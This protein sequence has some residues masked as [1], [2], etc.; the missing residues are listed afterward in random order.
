ME[1]IFPTIFCKDVALKCS[2]LQ[3]KLT[4]SIMATTAIKQDEGTITGVFRTREDAE[5]AYNS[6]TEKGYSADEIIVLMSDETHKVHF[7]DRDEKTDLGNKAMEKAGVG[8]AIGGTVGAIVGGIAA[9]GTSVALPGLGLIIAGPIV[10]ALTGAGAGGLTGGLIGGL[11]G[12][13]IP[14]EQ[15]EAYETSIKEGGIVVGVVP[16]TDED[17]VSIGQDWSTYRGE[18]LYGVDRNVR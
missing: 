5:R 10:A 3:N 12:S 11:I 4:K 6:L 16:R 18:K 2:L 17:R 9:I 14:K 15:A 13:G 8:S 1:F 7:K